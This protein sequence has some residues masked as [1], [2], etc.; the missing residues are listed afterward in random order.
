MG[1]LT[2]AAQDPDVTHVLVVTDTFSYEDYPVSVQR[3]QDVKERIKHY[4]GPNMQK[5]MEVYAMHHN[6]RAQVQLVRCWNDDYPQSDHTGA[7]RQ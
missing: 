2:E 1:W 4:D 7:S 6:L 3:S 5:V